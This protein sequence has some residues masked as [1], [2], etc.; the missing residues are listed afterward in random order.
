[1]ADNTPRMRI[2]IITPCRNQ[3]TFIGAT[4]ESIAH[5]KKNLDIE[6]IIIDG[7]SSD[8]TLAI[9]S[10]YAKRYPHLRYL[11]EPDTGQTNALNK[12]LKMATGE[13]ISFLNADDIYEKN[14][15]EQVHEFFRVHEKTQWA[16]GQCRIINAAGQEIQKPITAYKN[17]LM[18]HYHFWTLLITDYICQPACFWRRSAMETIGLFDE[19]QHL[20]MDY[21]YWLRLG[22]KFH[23]G[24][25]ESYLA[26]FRIHETSKSSTQ[27]K[28]Q[29]LEETKIAKK[30]TNNFFLHALHKLH[31]TLIVFIYSIIKK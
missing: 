9:I 29:F 23:P 16:Y 11:S 4:I 31:A 8:N 5:H 22:Q 24:F 30:F 10:D 15:L 26:S 27:F 19:N 1:M 3:E 17:F 7:K 18:R 20:V 14:A 13:I 21:E 25:I 2:S 28:K 6:H 12:G